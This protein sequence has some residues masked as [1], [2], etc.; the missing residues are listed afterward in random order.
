[1]KQDR[2]QELHFE[3]LAKQFTEDISRSK[4][5][6]SME[7]AMQDN[8]MRKSV[9]KHRRKMKRKTVLEY[10]IAF[11]AIAVGLPVLLWYLYR[12]FLLFRQMPEVVQFYLS[13]SGRGNASGRRFVCMGTVPC[14]KI[15]ACR[16]GVDKHVRILQ[17]EKS[18]GAG[19]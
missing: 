12:Q 16:K 13:G 18:T 3:D 2:Q 10:A 1:M 19:I 11:S 4:R 6:F 17:K 5:I 9:Q 8:T 14:E 15:R 7:D